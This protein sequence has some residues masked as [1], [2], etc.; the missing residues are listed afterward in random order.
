MAKRKTINVNSK[1]IGQSQSRIV[2][3]SLTAYVLLPYIF[4]CVCVMGLSS[5]RSTLPWYL[6][7]WSTMNSSSIDEVVRVRNWPIT[8]NYS[9]Y[10]R[11]WLVI[12]YSYSFI[13]LLLLIVDHALYFCVSLLTFS[14]HV[15]GI[16][17]HSLVQCC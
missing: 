11:L 12:S 13:L 10:I 5:P 6:Y 1:R 17:W 16:T 8:I 15:T 14:C 4:V 7:A 9:S 2:L 3:C